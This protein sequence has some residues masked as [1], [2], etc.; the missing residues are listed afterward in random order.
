MRGTSVEDGVHIQHAAEV[1]GW[2]YPRV[3]AAATVVSP[4]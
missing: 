3:R 4:R 1:T 2:P